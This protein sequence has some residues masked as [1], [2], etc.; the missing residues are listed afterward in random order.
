MEDDDC[1]NFSIGNA[2]DVIGKLNTHTRES[3]C[4]KKVF[5]HYFLCVKYVKHGIFLIC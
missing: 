4:K 1:Y 5:S 3:R 2:R